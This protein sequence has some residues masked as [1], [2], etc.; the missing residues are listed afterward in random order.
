MI[1]YLPI[2]K[3]K[4]HH[5]QGMINELSN[6]LSP[7]TIKKI[8]QVLHQ[9]F[10]QA[11]RQQYIHLNPVDGIE[12]PALKQKERAIIPANDVMRISEFCKT[13]VL[14]FKYSRQTR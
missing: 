10:E 5:I 8:K 9:I 11:V 4:I 13:G 12:T 6:T 3:I 2:S 7:S 14:Y 1:G